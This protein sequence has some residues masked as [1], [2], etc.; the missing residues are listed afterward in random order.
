MYLPYRN[1]GFSN[2]RYTKTI[3]FRQ[4]NQCLLPKII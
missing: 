1:A 2:V 3:I 4:I